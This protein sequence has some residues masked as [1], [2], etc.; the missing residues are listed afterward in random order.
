MRRTCI[1]GCCGDR[2]QQG[3]G[4]GPANV[5]PKKRAVLAQNGHVTSR[6]AGPV[7]SGVDD[8]RSRQILI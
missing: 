7:L 2:R 6:Y 1:V 4:M 8:H 3:W 5:S